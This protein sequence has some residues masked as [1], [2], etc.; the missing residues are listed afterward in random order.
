MNDQILIVDFG[1]QVTQ[2]IARRVR[3]AGVYCEIIP[4]NRVDDIIERF[5]PQ[6]IILSGGPASVTGSDTPRAP[7]IVFQMGLP[8]LGICYGCQTLC[9]QLGGA[10]DSADLLVH[11]LFPI[12]SLPLRGGSVEGSHSHWV[13]SPSELSSGPPTRSS[14]S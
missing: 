13:R 1:S 4:F 10:R 3:E 6:G 9:A 5:K 2:L 12:T 8:L 7:E 11:F 14:L